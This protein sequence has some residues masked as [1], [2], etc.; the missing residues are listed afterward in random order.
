[1][2]KKIISFE[3]MTFKYDSQA[4]PT[5]VDINLDIFEG[6]KVLVIGASGSG[7]STF[8]HC[9]NGLIPHIYPG[10]VT[11]KVL[12]NNKNVVESS[13]FDLSFDVGTVLQDTDGQFI[14]MTVGEDI[15]FA[16]EN[17]EVSIGEMREVVSKWGK[18]V[19]LETM[20]THKPQDLSGGQ[21]QRVS[22][23][24]VLVDESPILL[25]DE[26]LANLDPKSGI[27][28]MKLIDD[29]HQLTNNTII[30]IEHRI[31]DVLNYPIDRVICFS[32]GKIIAN[33]TVNE[34][35][36]SDLLGE[37]VIREPLYVTA[38]KYAGI[39]LE[40]IKDLSSIDRLD[41]EYIRP[42]LNKW[43]DEQKDSQQ[44]T[45][46]IP[47]L[48]LSSVSYQY[49]SNL[50]KTLDNVSVKFNRGDMISLV[51]PNGAGKSTLAKAICGFIH[52][53]GDMSWNGEDFS[54]LSIKE[55]SE[56]IGF[57][58]QNPNQMISKKMIREEVALGLELRGVSQEEIDRRVDEVLSVCGLYPYRNWPI[59]ALSYGQKKRVTIASILILNPEMIVL[60]EPTAGQD[61]K[62]YTEMMTFLEELNRTQETTIII[63]TH[64]M[65]LMLE[66]TDRA[67]V[68]SD[69]KIISDTSPS[70]L[71]TSLDKTEKASLKETS[72]YELA[73]Y[74]GMENPTLFV[75]QFTKFDR[76]VKA[77]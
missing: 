37:Q 24:G 3:K 54:K 56:K 38:L 63:I 71:L 72:L 34:L 40:N 14:G 28:A 55:R 10:G 67:L 29:I 33:Q 35:L 57:V 1:M 61:L 4:E 51:G 48:S 25:F 12:V 50:K 70:E 66:Y 18:E 15:A 22:L 8:G 44:T 53:T 16:L 49:A 21:K 30:I 58:M 17:D 11:G 13:I 36:H 69:G 52:A 32:D 65:H 73:L 23:A 43:S 19:G 59:S 5:L 46:K 75:E 60:D 9:L 64:D 2:E 42:F 27:E 68:L 41:K 62:H 77:R 26:P 7:K 39:P 76:G 6:E 20:M 74:I 47:L 45:E 31:E